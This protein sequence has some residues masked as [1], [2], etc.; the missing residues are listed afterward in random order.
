[1]QRGTI[2]NIA[3]HAA[4]S[5][6]DLSVFHVDVVDPKGNRQVFYSGNVLAR[7]GA[8][9]RS[10]PFA[11]SDTPGKWTIEVHDIMSG[12]RVQQTIDVQ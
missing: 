3:I 4:P 12:Q 2:A 11:V 9:V 1:V 5:Q 7:R 10:I 8:G 6:A